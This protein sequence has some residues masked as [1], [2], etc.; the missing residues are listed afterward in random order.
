MA[1]FEL[2]TTCKGIGN[3]KALRAMALP[4]GQSEIGFASVEVPV[5]VRNNRVS[6]VRQA[7]APLREPMMFWS[8]ADGTHVRISGVD[9]PGL[10]ADDL[11]P[12]RVEITITD[13]TGQRR[14]RTG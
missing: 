1:S 10:A 12:G 13:A 14:G 3:R 6:R 9:Y 2:F 11:R 5:S 7:L 4:A 8:A